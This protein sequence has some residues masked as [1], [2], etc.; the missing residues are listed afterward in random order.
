MTAEQWFAI[1]IL[2]MSAAFVVLMLWLNWRAFMDWR[3]EKGKAKRIEATIDETEYFIPDWEAEIHRINRDAADRMRDAQARYIEIVAD[4]TRQQ[5]DE[6][7]DLYK[8][9]EKEKAGT[10]GTTAQ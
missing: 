7:Y 9:M 6:R 5:A 10:D 2:S 8:R 1:L 3:A 4:L